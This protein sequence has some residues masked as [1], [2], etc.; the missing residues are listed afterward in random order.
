MGNTCIADDLQIW[1]GDASAETGTSVSDSRP[2][3]SG[4]SP[5]TDESHRSGRGQHTRLLYIEDDRGLAHLFRQRMTRE[6]YEVKLATTA[7][8]GLRLC[9]TGWPEIVATDYKLPDKDGLEVLERISALGDFPP[10]ALLITGAGDE[11]VAVEAMRRGA[12]D[13]LVKDVEGHYLDLLPKVIEQALAWSRLSREKHQ[14]EEALRRSKANLLEAQRIARLG[15]WEWDLTSD[16]V[17]WSN[18]IY[19]IFGLEVGEIEPTRTSIF[20]YI[21]PQDAAAVRAA[22][23][24]ALDNGA[25]YLVDYRVVRPAGSI[26]CVQEQAEVACDSAGRPMRMIGTLQDITE[27]KTSELALLQEKERA[28]VTLRSIG[29]AVITTDARGMIEYLNPV[30]ERL[31]GWSNEDARGRPSGGVFCTYDERSGDALS[32]PVDLCLKEQG[33]VQ[34]RQN[35]SLCTRE[36]ERL[37]IEESAA[38][39]HSQ[40]NGVEGV[41]LVFRDVSETRSLAHMLSYQAS[42]DALTGLFNR[43]EFEH[44]TEQAIARGEQQRHPNALLYLDLDQ[45]KIV[46]DTCG[47]AAGDELLQQI[48]VLLQQSIRSTDTLARLGGDEFGVLLE[49][50]PLEQGLHISNEIRQSVQDYR[51]QWN[52]K[53]FSIGVSIGLVMLDDQTTDT[54]SVMS[55]ADVA[56]YAAKDAGRNRIHVYQENDHELA[57]RH[58]DM[59][60]HTRLTQALEE[61]R[62]RLFCQPMEPVDASSGEQYFEILLRMLDDDGT[63]I[64][65]MSFL[66]AAERYGLM[67]RIDYHV[68]EKTFRWLREHLISSPSCFSLNL[69]GQSVSSPKFRQ[70]IVDL[71]EQLE[72]PP[73]QICFEITETAA[74]SNLNGALEFIHRLKDMGCRFA[75]D[76]FGSGLSSFSYLKTL[77]VDF[78]KIDGTF[79]KD[80]LQDPID[81]AMVASI[82]NIGRVM[83]LKVIAEFVENDDLIKRLK[84]AGADYLQGFGISEPFPIEQLVGN[85]YSY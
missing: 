58:G 2:S 83:G 79:V 84:E 73:Q 44:R 31:T 48:S 21:H 3:D 16:R 68:V 72:V 53:P 33:I 14:T 67:P 85:R 35:T 10:P 66:P 34:N 51:Y 8:E 22:T 36:G 69:S 28:Q 76:D 38:P 63:V 19:R 20:S 25:R 71:F 61:D 41:V 27:R 37:A 56:C 81:D 24:T 54:S 59:R 46:N 7:E 1:F 11:R 62:F 15:S 40:Q 82:I 4:V 30:A 32:N 42:H 60:W 43:N 29:D 57:R 52:G 6:G 13:Y 39:I 47:H 77:P 49:G 64:F 80:M 65:P 78:L 12:R 70:Q 55:A 74:I 9:A 18:E 23:E 75:L 45:F 17:E 26:R 5:F 50:C